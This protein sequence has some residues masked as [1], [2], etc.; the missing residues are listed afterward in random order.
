MIIIKKWLK[1]LILLDK[2]GLMLHA[3]N[4]RFEL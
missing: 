4:L 3:E 2:I 1:L